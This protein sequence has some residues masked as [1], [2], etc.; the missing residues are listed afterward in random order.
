MRKQLQALLLI[1]GILLSGIITSC[2]TKTYDF[3]RVKQEKAKRSQSQISESDS[4][5][6]EQTVA[7]NIITPAYTEQAESLTSDAAASNSQPIAQPQNF[8]TNSPVTNATTTTAQPIGKTVTDY[9]T[10]DAPAAKLKLERKPSEKQ[11]D[12]LKKF[13]KKAP[14]KKGGYL[15][16]GIVL[17]LVGLVVGLVF[18]GLGYIISVVGLVFLILGL[19][20]EVL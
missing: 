4:Y 9:T 10:N 18:G 2:A 14:I 1:S 17:L 3:V 6:A 12:R 7:S 20:T 8:T 15:W 16:I 13:A 11:I 5:P 19:L